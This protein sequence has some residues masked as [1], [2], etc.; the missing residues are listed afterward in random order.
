MYNY[1]NYLAVVKLHV[2]PSSS[3]TVISIWDGSAMLTLIE[4]RIPRVNNLSSSKAMSLSVTVYKN[5]L[6][7]VSVALAANV[8]WPISVSVSRRNVFLKYKDTLQKQNS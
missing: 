2:L 5:D 7:W 1:T 4:S 8:T 6:F 3:T